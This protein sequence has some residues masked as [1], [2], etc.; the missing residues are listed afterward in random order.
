[1]KIPLS[2][3]RMRISHSSALLHCLDEKLEPLPNAFASGFVRREADGLWL[4][5]CWHVVTG[6]DPY[7]IRVG[8]ELPRRRHLR[9]ALQASEARTPGVQ[10]IGGLQSVVVPLYDATRPRWFQDARH[11]PHP[12]LNA[13]GIYVPFWHDLVKLKLPH[14][15]QLS[16]FQLVDESLLLPGSGGLLGPGDKC[17][18]VGYPF[19][20][21]AHGPDQPAPV[22]LTRFVAS[23][24]IA[25]RRQQL[26][27]ESAGAP[28]MSGGPVFVERGDD[29]FLFGIYVGL[30]YPDHAAGTNERLSAL[31]VV[32]NLMLSLWGHLP[33]VHIPHEAHSE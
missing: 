17:M 5:T 33:L 13:V 16:D 3:Q 28:G 15:V 7:N 20:F 29:L 19:G 1:M 14:H 10:V 18:V 4:Y 8:L 23:D 9:V 31:G 2:T 12:D 27:L 22:A 26:L 30:I 11:V 21:S 25:N 24:R 6:F 32:S